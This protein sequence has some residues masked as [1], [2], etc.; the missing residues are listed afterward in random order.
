MP[1]AV[2]RRRT[3]GQE[4]RVQIVFPGRSATPGLMHDCTLGAGVRVRVNAASPGQWHVIW[5]D[6]W[7]RPRQAAAESADRRQGRAAT[8]Q[9]TRLPERAGT[10][11]RL[12]RLRLDGSLPGR[13]GIDHRWLG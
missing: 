8:R 9:P 4:Q 12:D 10:G 13:I 2:S 3:P 11:S 5:V 1:I 7:N 6:A